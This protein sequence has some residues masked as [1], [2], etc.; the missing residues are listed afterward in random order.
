MKNNSL[1][2]WGLI[3]LLLLSGCRNTTPKSYEINDE[4]TN[5]DGG[6]YYEIFVRSFADSNG[7]GQGD[8][9]G[10][11][12][13][14]D[15]L[16]EL[17]IKGIW[18][19]PIQPSSSYHGYDVTNYK[20]VNPQFGTIAD[21]EALISKAN[22]NNIDVIIDLVINHT[23][24]SH[25]WFIEGKANFSANPSSANDP[26]NKASWY[27]FAKNGNNVTYE[28]GFGDWMPDLNLANPYVV[29]EIESIAKFWLDLGVKGFRLDAVTYFFPKEDDSIAYL[30]SF[31]TYV[32][33]VK[34]DAYIVA[35]AWIG[36][37]M[38]YY[39]GVDSLFNF[40]SASVD[41]FIIKNIIR[42]LGS[43][44]ARSLN[45]SYKKIYEINNDALV[46]NF[47]TN[48]DMNR[49]SQMFVMHLPER[50]KLAAA[51]YLLTPGR[52][53]L[54]YGEEIALKGSRS[55]NQTDANRRLPMIWQLN[56]DT[57]RTALPPQTDYNMTTQVREGVKEGLETP[58]SL[59]NYYK[60]VINVRNHYPWLANA[61]LVENPVN[62]NLIASMKMTSKDGTKDIYVLHNVGSEAPQEIDLARFIDEEVEI[63]HDLFAVGERNTLKNNILT[64]APFNSVVLERKK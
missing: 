2:L 53:F 46:A 30:K 47:L 48:H 61:R 45:N 28:A 15:Y 42:E 52:P 35:E 8:L 57:M 24:N 33:S 55:T 34:S 5:N 62:N 21:F 7:D 17:G 14:L 50:Q 44:I 51:I 32:K 54:Y 3:P 43:N 39:K 16:E 56:N 20:A 6:V 58:F 25:P 9:N 38:S 19:T 29:S 4:V 60:K 27:N 13:K 11:S 37:N 26:T 18:L 40:N 49:S 64:L 36:D 10:I 22:E 59:L 23:S 41:G 31:E 63:A 12:A 1:I